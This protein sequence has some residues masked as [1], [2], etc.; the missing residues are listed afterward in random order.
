MSEKHHYVCK[1]G[2]RKR[3]AMACEWFNFY[4]CLR[5]LKRPGDCIHLFI[6]LKRYLYFSLSKQKK[7]QRIIHLESDFLL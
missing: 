5:E 6:S 1:T 3:S 2:H 4:K 7:S